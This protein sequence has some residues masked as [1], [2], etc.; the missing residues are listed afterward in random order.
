MTILS[1]S[2]PGFPIDKHLN[3]AAAN[4]TAAQK[5]ELAATHNEL[6]RLSLLSGKFAAPKMNQPHSLDAEI[7]AAE[8]ALAADPSEKLALELHGL[9]LRKSQSELT[10]PTI[11]AS[12]GRKVRETIDSLQPIA[13]SIIDN[14]E[15]AF[16]VEADRHREASKL[17]T[18]FS[19]PTADFDARVNSS[20]TAFEKK[21][22][23]IKTENS[24]AHFLIAELGLGA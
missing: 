8:I 15:A 7:Q 24:A 10:A 23:W 16:L 13:L 3:T 18:S 12:I 6:Q 20:L 21:R 9:I 2:A 17:T 5:K 11:A 22:R 19:A 4:I 1:S 14:A